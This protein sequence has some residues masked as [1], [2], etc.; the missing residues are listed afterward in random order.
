[1]T[2]HRI[3]WAAAA[4]AGARVGRCVLVAGLPWAIVPEGQEVTAVTWTGDADDAWHVG[5][6]PVCKPWL[7]TRSKHG[8]DV[9]AL[10]WEENAS[11]VQGTVD[12]GSVTLWLAAPGDAPLATLGARDA[13]PFTRLD[14]THSASATT[15]NVEST[16]AFASAGAV[17]LGRERIT[18]SGKTATTLTGCSRGTA[19]TR[20]RAYPS[21]TTTHRVYFAGD[22][23]RLPALK[24][25]RCTVWL[26]LLSETG[27]ATD[28][29][30]VYDGRVAGGA[31]VLDNGAWQIVL[32]HALTA[33]DTETEPPTIPLYGYAHGNAPRSMSVTSQSGG[34]YVPLM[35]YWVDPAGTTRQLTLNEASGDP[36]NGGWSETRERYLERW[37]RAA[38]AGPYGIAAQL[39]PSGI[40]QVSATD[41]VDDRRLSV[42]FGWTELTISDPSDPGD[43]RASATVYSAGAIRGM[44]A[45]CYWLSGKVY[46][47]AT[48]QALIPAMPSN[49]LTGDCEAYW[50]LTA[51][52]DN[53]V[54]EKGTVTALVQ[55]PGRSADT[56]TH[57]HGIY[58]A[59]LITDAG[60]RGDA[61]TVLFTRPA[62]ATLGLHAIGPRWWNVFRYAVLEQIDGYRGLDQVSGSI[63]WDRVESIMR[64]VHG[65][66]TARRYT[67]DL[68]QPA[69]DVLRNEA[70][71]YGLALAT[72]HGRVSVAWIRETAPSEAR[73]A[74][75]DATHLRR[76]QTAT[77]RE[78]S[79]G[80][81]TSYKLTLPSGD[82]LTVNDAA[83]IG[84]SG[85]GATIE[86]TLPDGALPAGRGIGDN[87]L[88][89]TVRQIAA[90]TIAPWCR[91]YEVVSWPGDLRLAGLQIGDV[92]SLTEWMLPDQQAGRG[93]E[94]RAGTVLSA[95]R[96]FDAG[97]VDLRFRL[98]PSWIAGYAP[99]ALVASIS[100]AVLT[101]DT[102]TLGAM[103]FAD[104]TLED[105]SPRTDGGASWFVPGDKVYLMEIDAT[106]PASPYQAEVLSVSGATVTLNGSPGGTWATAAAAGRVM[107]T[108]DDYA[109]ATAAQHAFAFVADRGTFEVASGVPG[110]RW[111]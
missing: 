4:A 26:Y 36:D 67:L 109:T 78:A 60:D 20:A 80:L 39:L 56:P 31:G 76:G 94:A 92:C 44:P 24:G 58:C 2:L 55:V 84:E 101:L 35:A 77:T 73:A 49:P 57:A 70:R 42:W 11:P 79:D 64:R 48:A 22:D 15:L 107:L 38:A 21:A 91:T 34:R 90:A 37:N 12:V 71:L 104:D 54:V 86:A 19:G 5:G 7:L 16:A 6:S 33:L 53:G 13:I 63:A 108:Y 98:S 81:A 10:A 87:G 95:R 69:L 25:R 105:D 45:A 1:M 97:T 59:P 27:D 65:H 102:A 72:W 85:A 14:G 89:A 61:L 30:L 96:D 41:G 106:S 40:L 18:Y 111:V 66:G 8:D 32:E 93:L 110:R 3:D 74:A 51:E 100:G 82:S 52:R 75:L 83:A 68:A 43:S 9:P 99:E 28:P 88:H 17:H 46:L 103:G 29:T 23:E 62:T 50:T 47:D